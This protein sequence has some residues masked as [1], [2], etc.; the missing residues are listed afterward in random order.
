ME[1]CAEWDQNSFD[2]DFPIHD[3]A[4]FEDD[5]RRGA[6]A[7][8]PGI[9]RSWRSGAAGS[10]DPPDH[11][12]E[13]APRRDSGRDRGGLGGGGDR[14][15]SGGTHDRRLRSC[16][17][18]RAA[19]GLRAW[20]RCARRPAGGRRAERCC[21]PVCGRRS[22]TPA[23]RA[24]KPSSRRAAAGMESMPLLE[25]VHAIPSRVWVLSGVFM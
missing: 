13:T 7:A 15:R 1:F 10:P 3:L 16:R 11:G 22:W 19:R 24:S 23:R 20:R 9:R 6:S 21:R 8:R 5:V 18:R 25:M 17:G 2:P 14:C 12:R 4:S